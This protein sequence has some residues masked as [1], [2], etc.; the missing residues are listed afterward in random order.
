MEEVR[1]ELENDNYHIVCI[2]NGTV[3]KVPIVESY[4][5]LGRL[6][7]GDRQLKPDILMRSMQCS[8]ALRPITT[9]CFRVPG[10]DV[11]QKNNIGRSHLFS[12][13]CVGAIFV[14]RDIIGSRCRVDLLGNDVMDCIV[15]IAIFKN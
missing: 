4:Q 9:R 10:I 3:H 1:A 13:L 11:A 6:T 14:V 12:V 5:H 8:G 2:C 15:S 7:T